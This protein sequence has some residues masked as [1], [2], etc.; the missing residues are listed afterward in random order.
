MK[1]KYCNKEFEKRAS[2]VQHEIRCS[3]NPNKIEQRTFHKGSYKGIRCD[4]SWELAYVVWCV[5]HNIPIRR[6][7]DRLKYVFNNEEH[8]YCPDFVVN[9][10]QIVEVKGSAKYSKQWQTKY[11]QYPDVKVLYEKDIQ[12]YI[13][14]CRNKYGYEFWNI[15]YD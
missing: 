14:Y 10:S 7:N 8:I 12:P 15:L 9:E 3:H 11:E 13:K 5:E 2:L 6:C 4:S 1:C